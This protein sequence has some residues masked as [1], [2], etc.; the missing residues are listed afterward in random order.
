MTRYALNFQQIFAA[1]QPGSRR[2][3]RKRA[4]D[5]ELTG[6]ILEAVGYR[7]S[8]EA[9]KQLAI[10]LYLKFSEEGKARVSTNPR[11]KFDKDG[12]ITHVGRIKI[13]FDARVIQGVNSFLDLS[14]PPISST[15]QL[16]SFARSNSN[17]SELG[18]S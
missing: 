17:S 5:S 10:A 9:I 8:P 2:R 12:N 16:T 13:G 7:L 4:L 6:K 14:D 1:S 3:N 11:V 18:I 15:C